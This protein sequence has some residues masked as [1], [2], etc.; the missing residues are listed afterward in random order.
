MSDAAV[1]GDEVRTRVLEALRE[2]IDPTRLIAALSTR[3]AD[4]P[5]WAPL[6]KERR[7]GATD[8]RDRA[9]CAE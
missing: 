6:L 2:V 9:R 5:R 7:H 8:K 1:E 3:A 4:C